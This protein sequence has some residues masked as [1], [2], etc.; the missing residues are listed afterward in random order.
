MQ[1]VLGRFSRQREGVSRVRTGWVGPLCQVE[2]R[3]QLGPKREPL[4]WAI[5]KFLRE[6]N[7]N[8]CLGFVISGGP[9]RPPI[10]PKAQALEIAYYV[11]ERLRIDLGYVYTEHRY[12]DDVLREPVKLSA[13]TL[14]TGS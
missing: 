8:I 11:S 1:G 3:N 14:L 4:C 12:G 7:E 10:E 9:G 2:S 6:R 13:F 5:W